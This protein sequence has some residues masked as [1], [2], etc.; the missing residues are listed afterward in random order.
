LDTERIKELLAAVTAERDEF[1]AQAN[2]RLAWL[3]GRIE[4]LAELLTQKRRPAESDEIA[5]D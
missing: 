3:N 2:Q 1:M 4:T 5:E